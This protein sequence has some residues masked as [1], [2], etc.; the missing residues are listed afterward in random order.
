MALL[1]LNVMSVVVLQ[2]RPSIDILF[3]IL[4]DVA[5]IKI[6]SLFPFKCSP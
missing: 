4:T 6:Y 2:F 1:V 5:I 3:H